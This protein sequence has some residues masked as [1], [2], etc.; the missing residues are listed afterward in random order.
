MY[1][2]SNYVIIN[3]LTVKPIRLSSNYNNE[4]TSEFM[5]YPIYSNNGNSF[6]FEMVPNE[7]QK[8]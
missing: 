8:I 7:M 1:K 6:H 4:K 2:L 5:W 3:F